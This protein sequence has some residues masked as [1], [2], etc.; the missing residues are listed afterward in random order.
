MCEGVEREK[1]NLTKK[2]QK[3]EM[4][5]LLQMK[6]SRREECLCKKKEKE[7]RPHEIREKKVN[8][9]FEQSFIRQSNDKMKKLKKKKSLVFGRKSTYSRN[10]RVKRKESSFHANNLS[11]FN[12]NK[13]KFLWF[14]RQAEGKQSKH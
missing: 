10:K 5:R 8:E 6:E 14:G 4:I 13:N 7:T 9:W 3:T 11:L 1:D 2:A 12:F